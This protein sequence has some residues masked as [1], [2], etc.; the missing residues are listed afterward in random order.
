MT[1]SKHPKFPNLH[2]IDHPLLQHKLTLLR[3]TNTRKKDFKDLI[4][5]I[6]L[7]LVCEATKELTLAPKMISTPMETFESKVLNNNQL[8]ILPIL[9]AGLG[10]VDAFLSLLPQARVGH[11]GLFRDEKTLQP[12]S[13]YLK[14][15]VHSQD[16]QF[17]ICDPMLATGGTALATLDRLHAQ[18]IKKIIYICIIAAP[19]GME[20]ITKKYPEIEFYTASLD[21]QLNEDGYILP[22]LGDAGDRLFGTK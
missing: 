9:R 21:R 3:D 7:L 13:Y 5:E 15:P 16:S 22:G 17:F 2:V 11:I 1:P 10:M 18:G 14:L 4:H 6:T 20:Q 19:E 8:V 12:V